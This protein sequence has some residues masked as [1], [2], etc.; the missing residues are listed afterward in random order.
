MDDKPARE[1]LPASPRSDD[2]DER[3]VPA[4][5]TG[6]DEEEEGRASPSH[7]PQPESDEEDNEDVEDVKDFADVT[8]TPT[9]TDAD[10]FQEPPLTSLKFPP[11]ASEDVSKPVPATPAS[12]SAAF[13]IGTNYG[14]G[15]SSST[16]KVAPRA[17]ALPNPSGST[18]RLTPTSKASRGLRHFSIQ[19]CR[20]VESRGKT[21][22]NEVADNLVRQVIVQRRKEDPNCKCD[23]KNIRRRVYD[24]L[25]VLLAM[26]ILRKDKKQIIWRGLPSSKSSDDKNL[27]PPPVFVE[28]P[29]EQDND[30]EEYYELL[31][32]RDYRRAEIDR[33]RDALREILVQQVCFRNL[34]MYNQRREYPQGPHY[35]H[36]PP[37]D[38]KIP[39]PFIISNTKRAATVQCDMNAEKTDVM[40]EFDSPFEI[41]DDN[42]IL[43]R[44]GMYVYISFQ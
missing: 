36:P 24:A 31:R 3:K 33:K 21:T 37:E 12:N 25:N 13:S 7:D 34:V 30:T 28:E 17:L 41:N 9:E 43:K 39:L 2:G 44:M 16:K 1:T 8:E 11:P 29:T 26:D 32:E 4:V 20:F 23:E 42:T 40:F 6:S 15:K 14:T 19:V 38:E 10:Y 22:Y 27:P 18:P 35:H 5:P